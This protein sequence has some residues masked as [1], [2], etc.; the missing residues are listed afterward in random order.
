MN[1][2]DRPEL[3]NLRQL[4][5]H[6]RSCIRGQDHVLPRIASLLRRGEMGLT[7]RSRPRG[8]FLFLG[9][10]GVGKTQITIAFTEFLRVLPRLERV[11]AKV[12]EEEEV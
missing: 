10:T 2:E 6:L 7:K 5:E 8:S 12:F 9:P 11:L 3:T 4:D 1:T